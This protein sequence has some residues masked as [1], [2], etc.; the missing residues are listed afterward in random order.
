MM[1]RVMRRAN[2]RDLEALKALLENTTPWP[3]RTV[4]RQTRSPGCSGEPAV[5]G[6]DAAGTDD[7]FGDVSEFAV[8]VLADPA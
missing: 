1:A 2:R 6:L 7:V 3:F 4:T 5:L 8:G